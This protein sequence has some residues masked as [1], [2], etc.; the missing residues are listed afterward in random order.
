MHAVQFVGIDLAWGAA[1]NTGLCLVDGEHVVDSAVAKTDAEILNWV[2]PHTDG[3]CVVAIDAP[4]IVRNQAGRRPCEQ[5]ISR[6]FGQ[7]HASA[8]S[9]NLSLP[10][11]IHGVRGERLTLKLGLD[12]DPHWKPRQSVQRAIEVYPHPAMVAL[13]G[14]PLTLKYKAKS[15]RTLDSRRAAFI[16][17]LQ[18]L[19]ALRHADPPLDVRSSPR[20]AMLSQRVAQ[21]ASSADLDRSEDELD[22]YVCAYIALHYW[23]HGTSRCR[24]VGDLASGY[25]VTPV[26]AAQAVCLDAHASFAT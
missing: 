21:P 2:R 25:I 4:L 24:V 11:F 1:A 17:L 19:E 20:W 3:D 14:I 9:S 16:E 22:A 23:T 7:H 26:T 18:H 5:A 15:G 6:R 8:H 13:F 10:A 12:V